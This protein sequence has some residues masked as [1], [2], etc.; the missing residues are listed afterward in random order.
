M[1]KWKIPVLLLTVVLIPLCIYTV[2]QLIEHHAVLVYLLFIVF[3]NMGFSFWYLTVTKAQSFFSNPVA[4]FLLFMT[5]YTIIYP[6]D[7]VVG[8]LHHLSEDRMAYILQVYIFAN[9][10]LIGGILMMMFVQSMRKKHRMDR[11]Q[12]N[13]WQTSFAPLKGDQDS[14][15]AFDV[16]YWPALLMLLLGT[17]VM[18]Y[19]QMRLGGLSVIGVANRLSNFQ[20]QRQMEGISLPW[21]TIMT[22]AMLLMSLSIRKRTQYRLFIAITVILSV[23]FFF[24]LGSRGF[25]LTIFLPCLAVLID[26]QYIRLTKWRQ[27]VLMVLLIALLSPLFTNTRLAIIQGIPLSEIPEQSWAFSNGETGSSFMVSSDILTLTNYPEADA[28]YTTAF[29][30]VLP[31]VVY[32]AITGHPKPMNLGDWYVWYLYPYIYAEGGG[33]GFSPL[34][35][36]WMNGGYAAI[37]AVYVI[38]GICLAGASRSKYAKYLFLPLTMLFQRSSFHAIVT[39]LLYELLFIGIIVVL[40]ALMRPSNWRWL[41]SMRSNKH[42]M[43]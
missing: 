5:L 17:A 4:M 6:L 1:G 7:H 12:E 40:A 38:I 14:Y 18:I 41:R 20:A 3:L 24:G 15:S 22:S 25:L 26:R 9:L 39:D 36:A 31:S 33:K 23:F 19:D 42:A 35:Q 2:F 29:G 43:Q 13:N 21:K 8:T 28:T 34:A 10:C 37:V 30:Y 32:Q 16:L 11:E 27:A